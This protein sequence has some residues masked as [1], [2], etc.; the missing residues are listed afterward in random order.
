MRKLIAEQIDEMV[1][2]KGLNILTWGIAPSKMI[3]LKKGAF[4]KVNLE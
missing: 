4:F 1:A 2:L 3:L